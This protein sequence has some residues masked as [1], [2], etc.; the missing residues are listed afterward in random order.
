[1]RMH[2]DAWRALIPA[3]E[4][5]LAGVLTAPILL[6][7]TIL[8]GWPTWWA[9]PGACLVT[10]VAWQL[11]RRHWLTIVRGIYGLEDQAPAPWPEPDPE[12]ERTLVT[13]ITPDPEGY[14][15]GQYID[16]DVDPQ[17]LR[18]LASGVVDDGLPVTARTWTQGR[19]AIFTP[20][21]FEVVRTRLVASGVLSWRR[22]DTPTLGVTVTKR[23]RVILEQLARSPTPPDRQ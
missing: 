20:H 3:A 21:E 23:G 5:L 1:M 15:E 14:D 16:V 11:F 7:V 9:A 2:D 8:K 18:L 17:R 10:L 12:P 4:G 22:S 19:R 13:V 6:A